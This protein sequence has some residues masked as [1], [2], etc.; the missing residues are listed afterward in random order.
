MCAMQLMEIKLKK[1]LWGGEMEMGVGWMCKK[2]AGVVE[3]LLR[4]LS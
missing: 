3:E 4:G 1:M 2:S